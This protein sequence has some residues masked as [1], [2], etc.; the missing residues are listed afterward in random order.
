[1]V[2]DHLATTQKAL[3]LAVSALE[4]AQMYAA[5]LRAA[6]GFRREP[7]PNEHAFGDIVLFDENELRIVSKPKRRKR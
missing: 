1:M 2:E 7:R 3:L 4:R 6:E 5:E